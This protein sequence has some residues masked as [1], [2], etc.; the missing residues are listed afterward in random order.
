MC[1]IEISQR[2]LS[3]IFLKL[4]NIYLFSKIFHK[5]KIVM[6]RWNMSQFLKKILRE[7]FSCN[8]RFEIFLTY[9]CNIL[10]YVGTRVV[11]WWTSSINKKQNIKF[12]F[13]S[14][15]IFLK[16]Y[17]NIPFSYFLINKAFISWKIFFFN[18]Y[19]R[20][21]KMIKSVQKSGLEASVSQGLLSRSSSN[22][23]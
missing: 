1:K 8:E 5:D 18:F 3:T 9:C 22:F 11:N 6:L 4:L 17:P 23:Y 2:N 20:T 7:Y 16:K 13:C 19:F 12:R 14:V 15:N 10:C 21:L